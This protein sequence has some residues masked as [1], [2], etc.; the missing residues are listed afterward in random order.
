MRITTLRVM[1][2]T[3]RLEA[4]RQLAATL[5][6]FKTG[7][8]VVLGLPR[9]GVP[10]AF[11]VAK[12]IGAPLDVILIRKL[13]APSQHELAMGAIGEGEVRV[14][15]QVVLESCGV[16]E[17]QLDDV[18]MKE[19][20]ELDRRVKL[21]RTVHEPM[22]LLGKTVVIV[23][24]GIATGSTALAACRVARARGATWI[25]L[26]TPVAP[27]DWEESM[28]RAADEYIALYT[29]EH[30]GAVGNFYDDFDQVSDE[31]VLNILRSEPE[32]I[33]H[34]TDEDVSIQMEDGETVEGRLTVPLNAKGCV[35]FVHG[36]GSSRMSPRNK[37]VA[38][39][40]NAAGLATLLFDL[41]TEEES[42]SRAHVFDIGLLSHRLV[43]VTDWLR[44]RHETQNLS[45]AYFG[46]S[47]GAAAALTAAAGD[48]DI[49]AVVSRGG[50]PDLATDD[51]KWVRCPV[52]LIV[53]SK[54]T[55][56]RWLNEEA[57]AQLASPHQVSIVQR[58]SHLFEE[59]GTLDEAAKL[60]RDF[61]LEKFSERSHHRGQVLAQSTRASIKRSV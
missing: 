5:D 22:S 50:R 11:E 55:E 61:L 34:A 9:G 17:Q 8:V 58:A 37:Q 23:D 53:G 6:R 18:E 46:A 56:V 54:D 51:L 33:D 39:V 31:D 42:H 40:L 38:R 19:R 29:P 49:V 7:D 13:G 1:R 47:T 27:L 36:S 3:N 10:V 20:Q 14:L 12:Y 44:R 26:A 32:K 4:G 28:G 45:F 35:V 57:A 25:A 2:F 16:S 15:N 52:L 30:F 60:A 21:Y 41:L 43:N 59:P 24:D 48:S